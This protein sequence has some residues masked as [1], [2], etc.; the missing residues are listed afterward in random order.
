MAIIYTKNSSGTIKRNRTRRPKIKGNARNLPDWS[1]YRKPDIPSTKDVVPGVVPQHTN[2]MAHIHKE[3]K[4]VTDAIIAKSKRI[5]PQY[6]KGPAQYVTDKTN[7]TE[8]G[9]KL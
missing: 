9:R 5:V 6:S 7:I 3:N 2:I 8:L 1:G 4:E